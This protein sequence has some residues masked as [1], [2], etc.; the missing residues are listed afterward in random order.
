MA[1]LERVMDLQRQGVSDSDIVIRMQNEG[2]SPRE[3]YDALNQARIKNAVSGP[4]EM[5]G[6]SSDMQP[7]IMPTQENFNQ[8]MSMGGGQSKSFQ[9]Q[10]AQPLQAPS[11]EMYPPQAGYD[12][13]PQQQAPPEY[14][15][16]MPQ[17]YQDAN[18]YA[19]DAQGYYGNQAPVD[20][21]TITEVAEQ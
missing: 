16:Q 3:I 19:P 14:Y 8:G 12:N 15:P 21:Q 10:S 4:S 20:T 17:A 9:G 18:A 1:T 5:Q 6:F 13:Y 11:P 2:V 7:S